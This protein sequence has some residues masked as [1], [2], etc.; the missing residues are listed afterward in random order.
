V[1]TGAGAGA[2][3][4][5]VICSRMPGQFP[6]PIEYLLSLW[7]DEIPREGLMRNN[8]VYRRKLDWG[9]FLDIPFMW[10][11]PLKSWIYFFRDLGQVGPEVARRT[12]KVLSGG[13]LASW[14]DLSIWNDTAPM[15]RLITESVNLGVIRDG[16]ST[17][18]RRALRI[19]AT[20]RDSGQLRVF[21]NRD[22]TEDTGYL[23]ILASCALP[24]IFP[25]VSVQGKDFIYGGLVMQTPLQPAV[26]AGSDVIYLV[27]NEPRA[28]RRS[29]EAPSA[30]EAVNRSITLAIGASFERDLDSRRRIN[31][32]LDGFDRAKTKTGVDM[33]DHIPEAAGHRRVVV[34]Q[35][36][37]KQVV[38]GFLDFSRSNIESAITLGERDASQHNCAEAG[39]IL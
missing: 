7:A 30:M 4:A 24:V 5:S 17:S 9:Q 6:S 29:G 35:F 1:F 26:D 28:D 21:S 13:N 38:G 32:M 31:A 25:P 18:P 33:R 2:F 36:R 27:H 3:N 19:V 11:R 16:E 8:R 15:R 23:A 39:C 20:E 22:F 14:L 37:P 34:H 10:R 12:A